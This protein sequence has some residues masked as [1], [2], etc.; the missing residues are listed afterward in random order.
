MG[1][2]RRV[3]ITEDFPLSATNPYGRSKLMIEEI[4]RDLYVA[5]ASWNIALLRYFNPVGAHP[6]GRIGEDPRGIPNNLLPFIAQVAV[7]R[8][9]RLSV[10]GGDYP[11][12]DGTGVRDYIHVVDLALG[13]IAAVQKLAHN[14]GVD[15]LQPGHRSGLQRAGNGGS[16]RAGVR[17]A[18]PLPGRR[19]GVRAISPRRTPIP[20]G[21]SAS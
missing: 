18:H 6:S 7:G 5:D 9:E 21:R 16:L 19:A 3:P 4:L 15:S 11:T 14:P 13:H 1:S 20:P 17:Q 8:L 10:F 2:R 12:P